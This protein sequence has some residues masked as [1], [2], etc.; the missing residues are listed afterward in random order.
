VWYPAARPS[1]K[2]AAGDEGPLPVVV[3]SHGLGAEPRDYEDLVVPWAAAGFVVVAPTYPLTG[4][5]SGWD[6]AADVRNQPADAAFVLTGVLR[7]AENPA[8][9]L[10]G[11]VDSERVVAVGHSL[12][13]ITTLGLFDPC[14]RDQRLDGGIVLAGRHFPSADRDSTGTAV[15]LL[16]VHADDDSIVPYR[17]G[18]AAHDDVSWPKAFVTLAD[19]G[20]VEP[21][22][23][24][25]GPAAE[26]VAAVTASFLR[27]VLHGDDHA[28][29]SFRQ[30]TRVD[31]VSRLEDAL[32]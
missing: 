1:S 31:G 5:G 3:F 24:G 30:D 14:C 23:G 18:R 16:F 15:P 25:D 6:T 21:Y 26:V 27:W 4:P 12:G 11:L 7:E 20:H 8:S 2:T 13:G 19:A 9:P 28:L 32:G 17:A 29:R 10:H 22:F